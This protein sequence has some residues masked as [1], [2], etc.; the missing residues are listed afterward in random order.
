MFMDVMNVVNIYLLNVFRTEKDTKK[1][2]NEHKK[3]NPI[4]TRLPQQLKK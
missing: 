1:V 2:C 3:K 4:Y